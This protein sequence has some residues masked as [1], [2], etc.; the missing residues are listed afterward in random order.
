VAK[1]LVGKREHTNWGGGAKPE[2]GEVPQKEFA[3]GKYLGVWLV[4][5]WGPGRILL[6]H[7]VR[8]RSWLDKD[9]KELE[10]GEHPLWW[11]KNIFIGVKRNLGT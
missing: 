9:L 11:K 3:E 6:Y 7:G 10:R 8:S 5:D 4:L 1:L 2:G